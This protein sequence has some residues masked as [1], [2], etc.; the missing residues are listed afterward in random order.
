MIG[1]LLHDSNGRVRIA[2]KIPHQPIMPDAILYLGIL[3]LGILY[4]WK[5]QYREYRESSYFNADLDIDA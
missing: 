3:Y 5:S 2:I 1:V 4:I